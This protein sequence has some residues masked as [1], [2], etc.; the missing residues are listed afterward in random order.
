MAVFQISTGSGNPVCK[1][2][3]TGLL[4][5]TDSDFRTLYNTV[6]STEVSPGDTIIAFG[7]ESWTGRLNLVSGITH[8]HTGLDVVFTS[9]SAGSGVFNGSSVSNVKIIGGSIDCGGLSSYGIFFEN[10]T[11]VHTE[12]VKVRDAKNH[13]INFK[14]TT[15]FSA[16]SCDIADCDDDC[17]TTLGST[18]GIISGNLLHVG[19]SVT[20]GSHGVEIEGEGI[21]GSSNI[22]VSDNLIWKEDAPI[23]GN[24]VGGIIVDSNA[25]QGQCSHITITGNIITDIPDRGIS[26]RAQG[27]GNYVEYITTGNNVI[28]NCGLNGAYD[29][30][31]ARHCTSTGDIIE[32]T[33]PAGRFGMR[34]VDFGSSG[35]ACEDISIIA[36]VISNIR[37]SG[38]YITQAKNWSIK[39]PRIS[40]VG[41]SV[42]SAKYAIQT[43]PATSSYD[44]GN[45]TIEDVRVSDTGGSTTYGLFLTDAENIRILGGAI[46]SSVT[47]PVDAGGAGIADTIYI[48]GLKG[49]KTEATGNESANA[50][51]IVVTH[52]LDRTPLSSQIDVT[53]ANSTAGASN[54]Y[55]DTIGAPNYT[56]Q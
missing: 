21:V 52:N 24:E 32:G 50:T 55:I 51:S 54:W 36:P 44:Y 35:T 23:G 14:L 17:I 41:V 5:A 8:I 38:I 19:T 26:I 46:E 37:R 45:S 31:Q 16:K 53:P 20:G 39:S 11:N 10:S 47:N 33:D 29:L 34:M 9:G 18:K 4:V 6:L 43:V 27:V 2:V 42:E 13:G 48:E 1:D 56:I 25:T 3:S 15:D 49:F 40:D 30:I 12:G 28:T 22:T 7:E